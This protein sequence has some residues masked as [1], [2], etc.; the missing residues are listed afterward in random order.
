MVR[1]LAFLSPSLRPSPDHRKVSDAARYR[2]LCA[3]PRLALALLL[4]VLALAIAPGAARADDIQATARGVV[5]VV[6]IAMVDEKVVGF[7]HG[8][9]FAVGP[10]RI[11]T[12]AH[13]V[14]LA[15]R[16]PDNVVIGV[17][18]SE[19]SKSYQGK[20][21]A[22][23]A[24][25]DLALIEF[26]GKPVPTVAL[27]SGPV[28]EGGTV[29]ALGY[30]GNV[31]LATAQSSTDYIHPLSPVR[32]EGVFSGRRS[33]SG[34]DVLLHTAGIARGNSGGPLLDPCG[35]VVGVNSAVTQTE[36]GDT[37]FAFAIADSA[38]I[39]FLNEAKQPFASVGGPCRSMAELMKQDSDADAQAAAT[40][41]TA[42]RDAAAKTALAHESALAKARDDAERGREN[43]IAIAA[44]LLVAGALAIGGAGM[45]EMR[46]RRR[47]ALWTLGGGVVLLIAAGLAFFLRPTTEP[48]LP[49]E[50]AAVAPPV[51]SSAALGKLVCTVQPD[52]S[53]VVS[54]AVSDLTLDWGAHGCMNERTQYAEDGSK[55]DRVLVPGEE[56]T[57][58]VL[59]FDPATRAY[60]AS[61]YF[62][63]ADQMD[64]LRKIRSQVTVKACSA[65]EAGRANLASQQ[66]AIRTT[67]PTYP[68]EKIVYACKP[69]G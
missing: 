14:E 29:V 42:R 59:Q 65:D 13:V 57:V 46:A 47:A 63:S 7:G 35:R 26:T 33:L 21:V 38:L 54:S 23:D 44:V 16:Y 3:W 49:P 18:P 69:A 64:T 12:N 30:P 19:G 8:S 17:V 61:R 60:T 56:Q 24:A 20:V 48:V 52:R 34:T 25:R 31:D 66:A 15:Q 67:L 41:E 27:Y 32:S 62:L 51:S 40:A 4:L 68:N 55:W 22:F 2:D 6:T 5:R 9:G 50:A 28:D 10:N 11:V 37:S 43:I 39:Q 45:L 1:S 58:S 36:D 53:R